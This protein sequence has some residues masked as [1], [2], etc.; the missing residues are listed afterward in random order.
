MLGKLLFHV[1]A[2]VS[3]WIGLVITFKGYV[4]PGVLIVGFGYILFKVTCPVD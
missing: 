1:G 3:A 2:F 4:I